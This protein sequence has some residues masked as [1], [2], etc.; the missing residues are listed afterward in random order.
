VKPLPIQPAPEET[1]TAEIGGAP[2]GG[3]G[4]GGDGEGAVGGAGAPHVKISEDEG[5]VGMHVSTAF[6]NA[7]G[8]VLPVGTEQSDV[9]VK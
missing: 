7:A 9:P 1:R 6:A 8:Y 3:G 4:E 2:T 5:P